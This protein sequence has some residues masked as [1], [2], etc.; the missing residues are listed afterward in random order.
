MCPFHA[1]IS[2][3]AVCLRGTG[4]DSHIACGNLIFDRLAMGTRKNLSSCQKQKSTYSQY[5]SL[6]QRLDDLGYHSFLSNDS[7]PLVEKL[8]ADLE[9]YKEQCA[10]HGKSQRPAVKKV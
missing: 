9:H 6:R 7:I 2:F 5:V 8:V 10:A 1:D 3:T 4:H